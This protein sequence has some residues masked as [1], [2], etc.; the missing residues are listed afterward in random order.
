MHNDSIQRKIIL[1][2]AIFVRCYYGNI[3]VKFKK[4]IF[5]EKFFELTIENVIAE[6]KERSS[7][8]KK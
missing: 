8:P 1:L 3:E 2:V 7:Q 5:R 4:E 6:I